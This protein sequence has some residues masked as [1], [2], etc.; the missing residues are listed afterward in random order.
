MLKIE[1]NL[2]A[3]IISILSLFVSGLAAWFSWRKLTIANSDFLIKNRPY[4]L[5]RDYQYQGDDGRYMMHAFVHVLAINAPALLTKE[6]YR[7]YTNK[8]EILEENISQKD[9]LLYN[10]QNGE[11]T[12]NFKKL[13]LIISPSGK[14]RSI[15]PEKIEGYKREIEIYYRALD[16]LTLRKY[17]S[18]HVFENNNW[19]L[20][21]ESVD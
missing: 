18:E 6:V 14:G 9:R 10:V 21:S 11:D 15:Y 12:F 1:E 3:L 4:I 5:V 8:D 7:I 20:L 16:G 19:K 2:M 17:K 13:F